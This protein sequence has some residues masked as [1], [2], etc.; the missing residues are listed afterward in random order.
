MASFST[1]SLGSAGNMMSVGG[2]ASSAIGSYYNAKAQQNALEYQAFTAETN[3]RLA[4][5][6]AQSTLLQ[7]EHQANQLQL[8]TAQLEGSQRASLAANGVDLGEGSAV[9]VLSDTEAMGK[10]DSETAYANAVKAAWGYRM[11]GTNYSNQARM[12]E[13]SADSISPAGAAFTSLLGSAGSVAKN[14]YSQNKTG[15]V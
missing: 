8:R 13:A 9:R 3:A 14:W 4:E 11:T 2:A 10:L 12:A 5:R 1:A 15:A 6:T 7:G